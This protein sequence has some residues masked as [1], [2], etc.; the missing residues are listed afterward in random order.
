MTELDSD[1]SL[2]S[3]RRLA[4]H[5]GPAHK[6]SLV[7]DDPH[8]IISGGE[9]GAVLYIDVREAGRAAAN[10]VAA[11]KDERDRSLAI[12]SVDVS[13]VDAN[14]FCAAGRDNYVRMYDRRRPGESVKKFCPHHIV[15]ELSSSRFY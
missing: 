7:P 4:Q 2:A 11:C 13:P 10:K 8:G 5:R 3:S 14:L 12:Y 15:S 9:D 1:G 6:L